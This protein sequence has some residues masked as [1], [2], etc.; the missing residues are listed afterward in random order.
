[1]SQAKAKRKHVKAKQKIIDLT[2]DDD[3][4]LDLA[5]TSSDEEE[6]KPQKARPG[7]RLPL[8]GTKL[9]GL[10][11]I[12]WSKHYNKVIRFLKTGKY[13]PNIV[14][15]YGAKNFRHKGNTIYLF[16]REIVHE[17]SRRKEIFQKETEHY[18]GVKQV[19]SRLQ[20]HFLGISRKDVEKRHAREERRQLKKP[21]Q[22]SKRQ[23]TFIV[24]SRPGHLQAD[25]TFYQGQKIPVF[26]A[27]DIFSRWCYYEV[28][29]SK[30]AKNTAA[31]LKNCFEA[32]KREA[33]HHKIWKLE[34]DKGEE[35][36]GA[37]KKFA[38]AWSEPDK[39]AAKQAQKVAKKKQHR[40]TFRRT[41]QPQR[42][43]E[44]L[45]GVLRRHVER[46]DWG[47]KA[48]LERIIRGFVVDKNS[49]VHSV[50]NERPLDLMRMSDK[51]EI[52]LEARRQL[53]AGRGRLVSRGIGVKK[54]KI[55]DSV[56]LYLFKDKGGI[57]MGHH[58]TD[59]DW[60]KQI[61][62]VLK[63]LGSTRGAMRYKIGVPNK[64]VTRTIAPTRGR[65]TSPK[66]SDTRT[67]MRNS[68]R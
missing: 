62:K 67:R 52:K 15:K 43:I 56:R 41:P 26:G 1:M 36:A 65:S 55:G 24:A 29:K 19:H 40:M 37:F 11:N 2:E 14:R 17:E 45:N 64:T 68:L 34:T 31:A 44:S 54:L 47:R 28:I 57:A 39:D 7:V 60:S 6:K 9:K 58:G 61:Y 27:I 50:T 30:E 38:E 21:R 16:D 48:E 33:P 49:S 22:E 42:L 63:T 3:V 23:R 32:F 18:G 20:N 8:A 12:I 25:L 66:E 13:L 4:D 46:V 10:L 59:P 35:F 53:K 51:K 5:M